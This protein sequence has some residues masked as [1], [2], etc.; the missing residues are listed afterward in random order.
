[1]T[2]KSNQMQICVFFCFVY[3][4]A[5]REVLRMLTNFA[6][7]HNFILFIFRNRKTSLYLFKI[8]SRC[9][10]CHHYCYRRT[11]RFS[12]VTWGM[13]RFGSER[14]RETVAAH[15]LPRS[16]WDLK[17]ICIIM[18]R[19]VYLLSYIKLNKTKWCLRTV[20]ISN[21]NAFSCTVVKTL[22]HII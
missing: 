15:F 19:T 9:P 22:C 20:Y 5:Q 7:C 11:P 2:I 10:N 12:S 3:L 4:W 14:W 17:Y 6:P 21:V 8:C 1:M 18:F 16:R 13:T